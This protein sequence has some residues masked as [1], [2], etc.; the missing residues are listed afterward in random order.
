M[1]DVEDQQT[2]PAILHQIARTQARHTDSVRLR[3][4]RFRLPR[5]GPGRQA[6]EAEIDRR[7]EAVHACIL[8]NLLSAQVCATSEN[9]LITSFGKSI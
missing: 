4:V 1:I 9:P 7:F 3:A 5:H 6:N 8:D 2:V